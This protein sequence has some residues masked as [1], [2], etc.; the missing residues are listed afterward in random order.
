MENHS[1]TQSADKTAEGRS[2]EQTRN[3]EQETILLQSDGLYADKIAR[4]PDAQAAMLRGLRTAQ[5]QAV[6]RKISQAQGNQHVLRLLSS[7]NSTLSPRHSVVQRQI[8]G[9]TFAEEDTT[10]TLPTGS[11]TIDALA[12]MIVHDPVI[13]Q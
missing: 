8:P 9:E 6:V 11:Y 3:S 4:S 10:I 5:R 1:K 2:S 7:I 12:D 13:S